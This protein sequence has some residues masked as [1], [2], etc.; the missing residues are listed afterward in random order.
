[1]FGLY[2]YEEVGKVHNVLTIFYTFRKYLKK[3]F[4]MTK[5]IYINKF[6]NIL[7]FLFWCS[8]LLKYLYY[9]VKLIGLR[10]KKKI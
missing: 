10:K 1:M 3:I 6:Q 2:M 5:W 7:R 9:S 4:V 8:D